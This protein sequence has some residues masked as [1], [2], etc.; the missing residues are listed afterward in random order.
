MEIFTFTH[1]SENEG[2]LVT[3]LVERA[4]FAVIEHLYHKQLLIHYSRPSSSY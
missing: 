1:G 3:A 4:D 2:M